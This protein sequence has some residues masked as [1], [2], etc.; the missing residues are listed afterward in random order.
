MYQPK[1]SAEFP[2]S[3]DLE[4]IEITNNGDDEVDLTGIYFSGTGFNYQFP[5][6]YA[7]QPQGV[8]QLANNQTTFI[9]R[10]GYG[11]FG[12]FIRNLSNNGQNLTLADGFGNVID[13]VNYSNE[14]PWPNAAA[15]GNYLKLTNLNVDNNEGTNWLSSD[16]AITTNF[17]T[18]I[19]NGNHTILQLYPNPVHSDLCVSTDHTILSVALRDSQGSMLE[20]IQLNSNSAM[21]RMNCYAP[22]IYLLTIKTS[23]ETVIRKIVKI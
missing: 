12:E 1:P 15:N 5:A 7:L 16:E 6:G 17:V 8:I 11:A 4:F 9:Q 3:T 20:T 19:E 22:G 21:L 23:T 18:G 10:Y 2:D 13:Q 14:A